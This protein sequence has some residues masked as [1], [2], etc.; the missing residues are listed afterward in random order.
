M[1]RTYQT[2]RV[3]AQ[4]PQRPSKWELESKYPITTVAAARSG[5]EPG[6]LTL[7]DLPDELLL[8]IVSQLH[9]IRLDKTQSQAFKDRAKETDRQYENYYRRVALYSL[10]LTSRRFNRLAVPVLYSAT[11]GSTTRYGTLCHRQS[12]T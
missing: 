2:S 3:R 1:A 5:T 11:V 6:S 7:L 10:C 8:L 12:P 4:P 9:A